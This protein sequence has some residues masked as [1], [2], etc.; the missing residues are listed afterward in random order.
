MAYDIIKGH[1]D[2]N[3]EGIWTGDKTTTTLTFN[4]NRYTIASQIL[5]TIRTIWNIGIWSKK[6][7]S[8]N[9]MN[10]EW[11]WQKENE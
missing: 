5:R 10:L 11:E 7:V 2:Q 6:M 1:I 8:T 9:L 4:I 3:T